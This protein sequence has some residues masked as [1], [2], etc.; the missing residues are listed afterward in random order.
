MPVF[1]QI[2]EEVMQ[3]NY[4]EKKMS[5]GGKFIDQLL[6]R[7]FAERIV[8]NPFE[9][10]LVDLNEESVVLNVINEHLGEGLTEI[11][12]ERTHRVGKPKQNKKKP[13]PT[14]KKF[15]RYNCRRRI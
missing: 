13:R 14:I 8:K 12:I 2:L 3:K 1:G 5:D 10:F 15:G 7:L 11:D 6:D 4:L 9:T